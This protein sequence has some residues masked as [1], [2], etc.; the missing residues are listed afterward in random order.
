MLRTSGSRGADKMDVLTPVRAEECQPV[1]SDDF[2]D[3]LWRTAK[4]ELVLVVGCA[5]SAGYT[6]Q[7]DEPEQP[8]ENLSFH[9]APH[10]IPPSRAPRLQNQLAV[11][12]LECFGEIPPPQSLP[13]PPERGL[14]RRCC[15]LSCLSPYG[16]AERHLNLLAGLAHRHVKPQVFARLILHLKFP[17]SV[18]GCLGQD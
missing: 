16:P 15:A 11:S 13:L 17:Q 2:L 18:A 9:F 10:L 7:G 5:A 4:D 3:R 14:P 6:Q 12:P 8:C 1:A